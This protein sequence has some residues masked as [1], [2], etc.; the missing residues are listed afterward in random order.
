MSFCGYMGCERP[1][2]VAALL[3]GYRDPVRKVCN[4]KAP[5]GPSTQ[6]FEDSG[7]KNHTV[8]SRYL[9]PLGVVRASRTCIRISASSAPSKELFCAAVVCSLSLGP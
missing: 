3:E 4:S 1:G 7:S 6:C 9:D 5:E 8:N 2:L